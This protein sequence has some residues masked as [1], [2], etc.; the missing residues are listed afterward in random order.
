MMKHHVL[1]RFAAQ[2][3]GIKLRH[4][5]LGPEWDL[6]QWFLGQGL[7]ETCTDRRTTIFLEPLLESGF[8]DIVAVSWRPSVTASWPTERRNLR[9][10][11]VKFLH[12]LT[13]SGPVSKTELSVVGGQS[14]TKSV[15]R[16]L[17]AGTI[18][19]GQRK[20]FAM[21]LSN[22][23]CV[24]RIV[25]IEAK[26]SGQDAVLRQASLNTWFATQSFVLL[27]RTPRKASF[28][29]HARKCGVGVW[30]REEGRVAG[31]L[32]DLRI[33]VSYASWLFNEWAWQLDRFSQGTAHGV[34]H[35]M[36]TDKIS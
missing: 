25:A 17:A 5:T 6:V 36:A 31:D 2:S 11:D 13:Q 26:T 4:T 16:L 3:L 19:V 7:E 34:G 12:R 28:V 1:D 8:P 24:D 20:I 33:P 18:R 30:T 32:K 23:Y 14:V 35:P 15:E 27:P 22:I 21:P 29:E 9:T 10:Q